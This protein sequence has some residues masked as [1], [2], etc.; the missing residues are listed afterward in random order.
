MSRS[1]KANDV[2][3]MEGERVQFA[4]VAKHLYRTDERWEQVIPELGKVAE[5]ALKAG[6]LRAVLRAQNPDCHQASDACRKQVL[7]DHDQYLA[8]AYRRELS[9]AEAA[10]R[11][12]QLSDGPRGWGFVGDGGVTVIVREVGASRRPEVKTAYR[13]VPMQAEARSAEDFFKAAV[14]KLQ[15]KS[16][17]KGGGT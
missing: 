12:G 2:R 8:P 16:S 11:F 1:W 15:D 9:A 3:S 6:C 7:G 17:W 10:G 5:R 14:R 4:H 13:V